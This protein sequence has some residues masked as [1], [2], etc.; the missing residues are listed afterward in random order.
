MIHAKISATNVR[1][2]V[3]TVESTFLSPHLARIDVNPAN[4]A[5]HTAR[6]I[7]M[8]F[9]STSELIN[10]IRN[11]SAELIPVLCHPLI[12]SC[13]N[14]GYSLTKMDLQQFNNLFLRVIELI[15]SMLA[16]VVAMSGGPLSLPLK[17]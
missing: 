10:H 5:E 16:Y 13:S 11:V 7:H 17:F 12:H 14:F 3:V 8:S 4:R 6:I 9:A 1:Y 2:A 15:I